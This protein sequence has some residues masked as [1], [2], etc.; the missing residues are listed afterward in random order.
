MAYTRYLSIRDAAS[1]STIRDI[2][3]ATSIECKLVGRERGGLCQSATIQIPAKYPN[4]H[5]IRLRDHVLI[6][7]DSTA[8]NQWW[9]GY[10][11]SIRTAGVAVSDRRLV[12]ECVGYEEQLKSIKP[13]V[14]F[15]VDPIN[16]YTDYDYSARTSISGSI[17]SIVWTLW[18]TYIR[19]NLDFLGV[20]TTS[21]IDQDAAPA[22]SAVTL[23]E[24]DGSTSLYDIFNSLA[25]RTGFSWGFLPT[26]TT[27]N[28]HTFFF[29]G[30]SSV[31]NPNHS[32]F[33]MGTGGNIKAFRQYQELAQVVNE[34]NLVGAVV[35]K[36]G[37]D[38]SRSFADEESQGDYSPR[39][40]TLEAPGVRITADAKVQ[41]A[42][43]LDRRRDPATAFDITAVNTNLTSPGPVYF[44][45]RTKI[46][47]KDSASSV[48][49]NPDSLYT[50]EITANFDF[51][52][53]INITFTLGVGAISTRAVISSRLLDAASPRLAARWLYTQSGSPA[54][55]ED[56]TRLMRNDRFARIVWGGYVEAVNLDDTL[57]VYTGPDDQ[58]QERE[59]YSSIPVPAGTTSAD[60]A[61]GNPIDLVHEF[62]DG[63]LSDLFTQNPAATPGGE[64]P[65][66]ATEVEGIVID[67]LAAGRIPIF[68]TTLI[69][70]ISNHAST[71]PD[72]PLIQPGNGTYPE[73]HFGNLC[74]VPVADAVALNTALYA[75]ASAAYN[76]TGIALPA[77]PANAQLFGNIL[78]I[79]TNGE[80]A[81]GEYNGSLTIINVKT[82]TA[83]R[84]PCQFTNNGV[85]AA[86]LGAFTRANS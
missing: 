56:R 24:F 13:K 60:W 41:A 73:A 27:P 32:R 7:Y 21:A 2:P 68:N 29:K 54:W 44:P 64:T 81:L 42:A 31:F 83:A 66:S 22:A 75:V 28:N 48:I 25:E 77:T 67:A 12:L 45:G 1:I 72:D 8:A 71:G 52:G 78:G 38:F 86:P 62:L 18:N 17:T 39:S 30:V 69:K 36:L 84:L 40:I 53:A 14:N 51:A 16:P 3:G 15:G 65:V 47:V 70:D 85:V 26:T 19:G 34:V 74:R 50:D 46:Q 49:L 61:I 35:P 10:V 23:L 82:G 9:H 37:E 57:D 6:G 63:E 79:T 5:G 4:T 58:D 55:T 80:I 20:G 11:T 33:T 76:T 43:I 59:L